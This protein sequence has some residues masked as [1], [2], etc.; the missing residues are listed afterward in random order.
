MGKKCVHV[1]GTPC[2]ASFSGEGFETNVHYTTFGRRTR[3]TQDT[4]SCKRYIKFIEPLGLPVAPHGLP[5]SLTV[6]MSCPQRM[7]FPPASISSWLI[8]DGYGHKCKFPFYQQSYISL[9]KCCVI[10]TVLWCKRNIDD[11]QHDLSLDSVKQRVDW[12]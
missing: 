2:T 5:V 9:C 1:L 4:R 3:K 6:C 11:I 12:Q 8:G 10:D 7:A